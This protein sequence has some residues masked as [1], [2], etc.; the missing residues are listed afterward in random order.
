MGHFMR[1]LALA[2]TWIEMGGRAIFAMTETNPTIDALLHATGASLARLTATAGCL[3][4][5]SETVAVAGREGARWIVADGYEFAAGYQDALRQRE[6]RVLFIDDDGRYQRYEADLIL[7]QNAH[8]AETLYADRAAHTRLLLGPRYALLRRQFQS[9]TPPPRDF[10][11]PAR[12]VLVTLG[13]ADPENVTQNIIEALQAMPGDTLEALV[14][15]GGSNI[16]G[17]KLEQAVAASPARINLVRDAKNMPELM[18]WADVA[19]S[20]AGST[21]LELAY[22]GV[23]MLLL[24]I[25]DNQTGVAERMQSLGAARNLGWA[26]AVSVSAIAEAIRELMIDNDERSRLSRTALELVDGRGTRRVARALRQESVHLRPATPDDAQVLWRWANDP[27]VR[28]SAFSQDQIPWG[29]HVAWLEGKLQNPDCCLLMASDD[30][31]RLAG[32]IRFDFCGSEAEIDLSV[33]A[34]ARGRGLASELIRTG[35]ARMAGQRASAQTFRADVK[36]S[37]PRSL[38]AFLQAGFERVGEVLHRGEAV[39]QLIF[40]A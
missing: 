26:H 14:V 34:E 38:Q 20:A 23:P 8:A 1:C 7:N 33:A 16:H 15:V 6:N 35:V 24:V 3:H 39:V 30:A 10:T 2:Q 22:M 28:A 17:A 37:N 29:D 21:T 13:G 9:T 40:R 25:A 18:A 11:R 5:A 4:D 36:V 19:V 12:K 31:G 27:V 32:Q